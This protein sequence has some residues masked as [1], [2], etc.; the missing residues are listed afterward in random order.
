M[1]R[2]G[3]CY[4]RSRCCR[5]RGHHLFNVLNSERAV[6]VRALV[7]W[8]DSL[9][10]QSGCRFSMRARYP[11][12]NHAIKRHPIQGGSRN[13]LARMQTYFE[14]SFDLEELLQHIATTNGKPFL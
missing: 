6:R 7:F 4:Y 2:S 1:L 10:L 11:E 3:C 9:L 12:G 8:Q 14:F 5:R 13:T